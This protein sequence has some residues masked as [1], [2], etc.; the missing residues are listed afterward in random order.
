MGV[1]SSEFSLSEWK[2]QS[3]EDVIQV[4]H[5]CTSS[6][7]THPGVQGSVNTQ[8][9]QDIHVGLVNG[10][11]EGI[12]LTLGVGSWSQLELTL[13]GLSYGCWQC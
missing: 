5:G 10:S 13:E 4:I 7:R 2:T 12:N 1:I 8:S 11:V 9:A 3:N 6:P